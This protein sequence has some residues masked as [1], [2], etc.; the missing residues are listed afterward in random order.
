[1]SNIAGITTLTLSLFFVTPLSIRIKYLDRIQNLSANR[2][3]NLIFNVMHSLYNVNHMCDSNNL[4][5]KWFVHMDHALVECGMSH[6]FNVNPPTRNIKWINYFMNTSENIANDKWLL[7]ASSKSSLTDYV[8]IKSKPYLENYLLCKV[9]FYGAAL[10]FKARSNTLP[11]NARI[12]SWKPNVDIICPLCNNDVDDLR[13]FLFL[14]SSLNCIRTDEYHKL[15]N[16]LVRQ[17]LQCFWYLFISGNLNV[18][19][20]LMLGVSD[21]IN[22]V[23]LSSSFDV[24]CKSYLKRAW[25]SRTAMINSV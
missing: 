4:R 12:H 18:K 17:D 21:I 24:F 5:W 25:A 20:S 19:M 22:N 7:S 16:R 15:Q 2:W 11:L 3:P 6:I 14:C 13:H 23:P 9:D 8:L 1:M 10:K